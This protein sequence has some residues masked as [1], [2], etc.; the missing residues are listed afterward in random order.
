MAIV[1]RL[2]LYDTVQGP[3]SVGI[4]LEADRDNTA[5]D[6]FDLMRSVVRGSWWMQAC[7]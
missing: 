7:A 2:E 4:E 6:T 5:M 3:T 1:E